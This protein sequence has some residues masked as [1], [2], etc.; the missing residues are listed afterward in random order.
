MVVGVGAL[1]G[2]VDAQS[3]S[4]EVEV[5]R[6]R[7]SRLKME[8]VSGE[9]TYDGTIARDGRYEF[10][11][12]SGEIQLFVPS[13]VGAELSLRT[14]S[15]SIDTEFPLTMRGDTREDGRRQYGPRERRMDFTLGGGGDESDIHVILNMCQDAL[16]FEIPVMPG[17]RWLRVVDTALESPDEIAAAGEETPVEGS[18]YRAASH[19]VVVLISK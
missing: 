13:D 4:G 19:S 15:G 17:R 7:T 12:H 6:A 9:L 8:S 11:S 14:F 16:D 2:E 3:V 18:T 1:A 5:R 10:S